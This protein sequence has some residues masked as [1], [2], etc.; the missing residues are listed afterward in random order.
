MRIRIVGMGGEPFLKVPDSNPWNEFIDAFTSAGHEIIKDDFGVGVD[1]LIANHHSKPGIREAEES[2]VPHSRRAIILWEPYI[3]ERTRYLP[4]NYNLYGLRFAPSEQWSSL[5]GGEQFPWPQDRLR[6]MP[7]S[8]KWGD[9]KQKYVL[10]QGNKFS[11]RKGELYSL[12]RKLLWKSKELIEFYGVGWHQGRSHDLMHWVYSAMNSQ[13]TEISPASIRLFGKKYANY[14]GSTLDKVEDM[15]RYRFSLVIE[16]SPDYVSE[17]LF[18]SVSAGCVSIYVGPNLSSYGINPA[19]AI[20]VEPSYRK[21]KKKMNELM[22]ISTGEAQLMAQSQFESMSQ[23]F[24]HWENKNVLRN[25]ANK[26]I[27]EM[28]L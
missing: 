24:P 28:K 16:N 27:E 1:V 23:A 6:F 13:L 19:A 8:E 25:L 12:R 26:I 4:E 3:V 21:I 10:V 9:R 15:A 2:S 22:S 11:A 14:L 20:Q 18:D 7:N 17:K 5:I